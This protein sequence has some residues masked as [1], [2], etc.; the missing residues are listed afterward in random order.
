MDH[1]AE[2]SVAPRGALRQGAWTHS[3]GPADPERPFDLDAT[4][5]RANAADPAAAT[6]R[7]RG[8]RCPF[9][10][11]PGHRLDKRGPAA[12]QEGPDDSLEKV[13]T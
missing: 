2:G 7:V 1:A 4:R 9:R 6:P 8:H 10:R 11:S 12:P 13:R 3:P 5:A